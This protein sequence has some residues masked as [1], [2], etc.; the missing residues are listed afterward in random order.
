MVFIGDGL[1]LTP[2]IPITMGLFSSAVNPGPG[3][4]FYPHPPDLPRYSPELESNTAARQSAASAAGVW[5]GWRS[6]KKNSGT[7]RSGRS[8]WPGYIYICN[9]YVIYIYMTQCV[10][11]YICICITLITLIV[12]YYNDNI[13]NKMC[14]YV[15]YI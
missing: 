2:G 11:I 3:A 10:Y 5:G 1:L 9:M 13:N 6:P 8:V 15:L 4:Q 12:T 7:G 14:V